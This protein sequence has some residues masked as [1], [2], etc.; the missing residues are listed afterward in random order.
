MEI[1]SVLEGELRETDVLARWGG[2]EFLILMRDTDLTKGM[3]VAQKLK[4]AV[5]RHFEDLYEGR[6]SLSVGVTTFRKGDTV[7]SLVRRADIAMYSAKQRGKD[8]I[9]S[10]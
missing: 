2:E 3:V 8:T 10:Y 4:S 6:I 5:R 7:N 1:A 9:M